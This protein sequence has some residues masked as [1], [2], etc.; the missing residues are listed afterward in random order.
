MQCPPCSL[1]FEC[2][3]VQGKK[4]LGLQRERVQ[5]SGF[6]FY[7]SRFGVSGLE[8][9]VCCLGFMGVDFEERESARTR[10]RLLFNYHFLSPSFSPIL[11]Q[12][13]QQQEAMRETRGGGGGDGGG[14]WYV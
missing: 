6:R 8:F 11:S 9:R 12:Q 13:Q 1:A 3:C 2:V 5:G 10:A 7:R 14:R 4:G